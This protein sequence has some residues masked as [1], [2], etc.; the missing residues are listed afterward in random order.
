MISCC[1]ANFVSTISPRLFEPVIDI[2]SQIANAA[3]VV[4]ETDAQDDQRTGEGAQGQNV[5]DRVHNF[6]PLS[7]EFSIPFAC[8]PGIVYT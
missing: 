7:Y 3:V 1:S 6:R 5:F 8:Y 2:L 4:N